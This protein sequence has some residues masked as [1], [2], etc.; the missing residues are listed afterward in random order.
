MKETKQQ[1]EPI[2]NL[3]NI[4]K[5]FDDGAQILKD[6]NMYIRRN[7]F[8]TLL[9]PSGC[10]KTTLLRIIGGFEEASSGE[11]L[12][13]GSNIAKLPPYKRRINTVFQKYALFPH[14]TVGENIAFGLQIKKV[15]QKTIDEKV[16]QMLEL[17]NLKGFQDRRIESLSGGQQQRIAIARA[18]VNEPTV[19]TTRSEE[20]R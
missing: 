6:I 3:V 20:R 5:T 14:M 12:F 10:G 9:G 4:S 15:D 8:L 19:L 11:V 18:V 1:T 17:V 13:E 2:I 7:E 16:A